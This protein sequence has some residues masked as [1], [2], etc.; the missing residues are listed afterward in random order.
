MHYNGCLT[1]ISNHLSIT[2]KNAGPMATI[3]DRFQETIIHTMWK[4]SHQ[5][6]NKLSMF[7]NRCPPTVARHIYKSSLKHTKEKAFFPRIL[8]PQ[9]IETLLYKDKC[10]EIEHGGQLT[11]D[12]WTASFSKDQQHST[13]CQRHFLWSVQL[14]CYLVDSMMK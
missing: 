7:L 4:R 9:V 2:T 5:V 8:P 10:I 12:R 1:C 11:W 3:L 6:C 14:R 13:T